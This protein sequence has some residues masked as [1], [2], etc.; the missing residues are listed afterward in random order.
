MIKHL[1][2]TTALMALLPAHADISVGT[3]AFSYSQSFDTLTTSTTASVW[4]NDST[5]AGWSLFI[6]TGAAAPTIGA[7]TGSS[8]AG[9][10]R[11]YGAAAA[12]DRALG[13]LASGGAY[14]GSPASGAV[15]GWI[16]VAFNNGTGAALDGFTL[17]YTGEQWRNG[18]NTNAQSLTVQYGYGATF[19]DVNVWTAA[20]AG[21]D[22]TSPV[23]G[24]TAGAVDGN[25]AGALSGLG[26]TV[27]TAWAA[28]QTLWVRWTDVNDTGNDHGL[29]L[30]NVSFGVVASVVPEPGSWAMLL[31]GS[32]AIGFMLRRNQ[33]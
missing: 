22:F 13:N 27:T 4:A 8:N 30:D 24:A 17:G 9:T 2:A 21:F 33:R 10:F 7:D 1:L 11:S 18:G 5:L 6:S 12:A 31:A 29:A 26:G 19:A 16:A 3:T 32:A 14:F 20:G 23:V 28:G 15:A 25:T